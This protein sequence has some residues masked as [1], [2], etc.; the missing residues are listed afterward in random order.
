[1]LPVLYA[2]TES[3]GHGALTLLVYL[4][5]QQVEGHVIVP[6]VMSRTVPLH[7]AAILVGVVVIGRLFGS[8]ACSWP[9]RSCRLV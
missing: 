1:V 7:P 3:I 9:C 4:L 8:W 2:S 6:L 5:V